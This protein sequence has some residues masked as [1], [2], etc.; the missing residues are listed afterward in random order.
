MCRFQKDI[1]LFIL[2]IPQRGIYRQ[3]RYRIRPRQYYPP[4]DVRV[5][6][7]NIL[8]KS[9]GQHAAGILPGR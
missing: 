5:E 8:Y 9:T 1:T 2:Q 7:S 6:R 3:G 4:V